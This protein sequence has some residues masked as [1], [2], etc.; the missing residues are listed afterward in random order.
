MKNV[1]KFA[2][3]F[4]VVINLSCELERVSYNEIAPE[5]FFRNEDDIN[6]ALTALYYPFTG[7]WGQTYCMDQY[8]YV[9]VSE[10][11][12]GIMT[13]RWVDQDYRKYDGHDWFPDSQGWVGTFLN[14]SYS[15]YNQLTAIENTIQKIKESPVN[16]E[17]KDKA[18]A[19]GNILYSWLAYQLY[20]MFGP[21]PLATLKETEDPTKRIYIPRLTDE[22]FVE[23]MIERLDQAIGSDLLEIRPQEWGRVNKGLAYIL[24]AKFLMIS[25]D[26]VEAEKTLRELYSFRGKPYELQSEYNRVFNKTNN[27][28]NEIIHAIPCGLVDQFTNYSRIQFLPWGWAGVDGTSSNTVNGWQTFSL[29]WDFYDKVEDG[30]KRKETMIAKFKLGNVEHDRTSALM[31]NSGPIPYKIGDDPDQTGPNGTTDIVVFRF[32]DVLLSLAECINRNGGNIQ[33]A[34]GYVNEVRNR[35]GLESLKPEQYSSTEIFN[36]T[37]LH[38]RLVEFHTEGLA[39]TDKIRFGTFVSDCKDRNPDDYQTADY[40]VRFP[41]PTYY[42]NESKG[43]V[44]QNSGYSQN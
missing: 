25:N 24:K 22:E 13:S 34:V 26:F 12:A 37:I 23:K 8:S 19:E 11:S 44:K 33:E 41:I 15:R 20:D 3:L 27:K 10:V 31:K 28:N 21:V 18:V 32:A 40:K 5:D 14:N 38:E 30:D 6:K 36:E 1:I 17:L 43:V 16:D 42:I 39:R 35:A 4:L 9:L 7:G 2:L 29:T